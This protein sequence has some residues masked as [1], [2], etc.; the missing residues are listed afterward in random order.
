MQG[1]VC[2]IRTLR[3]TYLLSEVKQARL[4]FSTLSAMSGP[5]ISMLTSLYVV[6]FV[7]V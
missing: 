1:N 2:L 6:F 7:Y 3:L 5:F 4:L